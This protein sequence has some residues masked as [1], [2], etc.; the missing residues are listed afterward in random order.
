MAG[1]PTAGPIPVQVEEVQPVTVPVTLEYLGQTEAFQKVD[2]RARVAAF[3]EKRQFEEGAM[4]KEGQEL[5]LLERASFEADVE[6]AKAAQAQAEARYDQAQR[7]MK[8]FEDLAA[9]DATT[10]QE[11]ED[12]QKNVKVMMADCQAAKARLRQAELNLTYTVIHSP[13]TG[14]VG[15]TNKDVGSY[16]SPQTDGPLVLVQQVD[17]LYIEFPITERDLLRWR[18]LS[19]GSPH[20]ELAVQ[21]TLPDGNRYP[22]EGRVNFVDISVAPR[23]GTALIRAKLDNPDG[24]LRPGQLLRVKV[25]GLARKNV[26]TVAQQAVIQTAAGAIVFIVGPNDVVQPVPV[27][28]GDWVGDRWVIEQGLQPGNRVIVDHMIQMRPGATVKPTVVA[29]T[30]IA[31]PAAPKATKTAATPTAAPKA[32]KTASPAATPTA[33]PADSS[34]PA[35]EGSVGYAC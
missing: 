31:A 3:L 1:P 30:P 5:F 32:S 21:L 10:Q 14:M 8:R 20:A 25:L 29:A 23:T 16:L 9:N 19:D 35:K 26:L 17:P 6:A 7:D 22:H 18:E 24:V 33:V 27:V 13:L 4:V 34:A 2:V 15:K 28:L 11:L 12:S